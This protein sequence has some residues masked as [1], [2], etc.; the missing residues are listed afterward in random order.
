MPAMMVTP[1]QAVMPCGAMSTNDA[2]ATHC[3]HPS[4]AS[5]SDKG[6]IDRGILVVIGI[7]IG[8]VVV[9]DASDKGAAE[10]TPVPEPA[11]GKSGTSCDAGVRW[12][13]RA[14]VHGCPARHAAKAA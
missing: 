1:M 2:R 7:I 14:A 12:T 4:A 10:V 6:G 13:E 8:V 3:H 11:A 9:V 5:S